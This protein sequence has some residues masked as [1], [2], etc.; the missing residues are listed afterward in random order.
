[1]GNAESLEVYFRK[2]FHAAKLRLLLSNIAGE[3]KLTFFE[4]AELV[5]PG[6]FFHGR[7]G[8]ANRETVQHQAAIKSDRTRA[9]GLAR[10]AGGK[11]RKVPTH[12][13][14][15]KFHHNFGKPNFHNR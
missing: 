13:S 9:W 12:M 4:D 14:P 10:L 8:F 11:S 2:A 15:H 7:D 3:V 6:E 5:K 1:M